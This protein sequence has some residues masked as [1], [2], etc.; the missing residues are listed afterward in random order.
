MRKYKNR[1]HWC[2]SPNY[3][4]LAL[5]TR[6]G[7]HLARAAA[8]R[9]DPLGL[10]P[11]EEG[12]FHAGPVARTV[13][14]RTG[15]EGVGAFGPRAAARVAGNGLVELEFL[16][17]P[18][19]DLR[20]GQPDFDADKMCIRDSP[21]YRR[22]FRHV[23]SPGRR[24]SGPAAGARPLL[25]RNDPLLRLHRAQNPNTIKMGQNYFPVFISVMSWLLT[26]TRLCG[27][28]R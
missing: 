22:R 2:A 4:T 12:V 17:G 6:I 8:G 9:A 20:E 21:L 24:H 27:Y 14:G 26:Y 25:G 15:G 23:R 1:S 18:G 5:V 3:F 10:H 19:G 7:N 11:A 16:G 13:A 28:Q